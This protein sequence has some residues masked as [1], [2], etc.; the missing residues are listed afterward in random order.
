MRLKI[1]QEHIDMIAPLVDSFMAA[2]MPMIREH[3]R[4]LRTDDKVKDISKRL[5]FDIL[6]AT[7][8]RTPQTRDQFYDQVYKYANDT[9]IYSVLKTIINT[10]QLLK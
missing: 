9:N 2:N 10:K 5:S 3:I 1:R 6:R 7:L 8:N 4:M